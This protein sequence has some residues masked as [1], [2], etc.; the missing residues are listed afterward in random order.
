VKLD[1]GEGVD[2]VLGMVSALP[3]FSASQDQLGMAQVPGNHLVLRGVENPEEYQQMVQALNL[4]ED[5]ER[6]GLYRERRL[7]KEVLV[8]LHEWAHALGAIHDG[9]SEF[10]MSPTYQRSQ[11]RFSPAS[12]RLVRLGLQFHPIRSMDQD[13]SRSW[14][15]GLQEIV[16]STPPDAWERED[17]AR[18]ESLAARMLD[19]GGDYLPGEDRRQFEKAEKLAEGAEREKAW[20]VVQPLLA[21]HP[22]HAGIQGLGCYLALEREPRA[23]DTR[24]RCEAAAKLA[25]DDGDARLRLAH[26]RLLQG[27]LP[28]ASEALADAS[29]RLASLFKDFP[30]SPGLWALQCALDIRHRKNAAARSDCQ[31]AVAADD[32]NAEAH[33][34]LGTLAAWADD[35]PES[36]RQLERV[37]VLDPGHRPTWQ[38]LAEVYRVSG[39]QQA[40]QDL[41][42]R[43][44]QIY[45]AELP[46]R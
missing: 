7:H 31:K 27:D 5:S 24:P 37:L 40:L 26:A 22:R 36:S 45:A 13:A 30:G 18:L 44:R 4:L 34:L 2:L 20:E 17:R 8:L 9:S 3:V 15:K 39:K 35:W 21:R 19:E 23:P 43:Y 6:E 11:S 25:P 42:G 32:E 29:G 14:A 38:Q 12:E 41:R 33:L 16:R 28:G 10:V 1:S 46:A